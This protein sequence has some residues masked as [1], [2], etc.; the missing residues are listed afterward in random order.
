MPMFLVLAGGT[1]LSFGSNLKQEAC[2]WRHGL[3]IM[4]GVALR[5]TIA[6]DGI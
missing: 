4:Y 1:A 6:I 5:N 2:N 3:K